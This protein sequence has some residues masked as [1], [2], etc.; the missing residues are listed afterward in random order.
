[1]RSRLRTLAVRLMAGHSRPGQHLSAIGRTPEVASL[2]QRDRAFLLELGYG[3]ERWRGKFDFYIDQLSRHGVSRIDPPV[4][5]TLRGALYE[6]EQMRTPA[7]AAVHE[8]V[9]TCRELGFRSAAGFVNGIL[10][11]F[12]RSPPPLPEDSSSGALAIRTSHPEWL[13]RRYRDR[14]GER[15]AEELL[16]SNNRPSLPH[17]WV[18]PFK[19]STASLS[20]RLEQMSI[21]FRAHPS[22]PD[23]LVLQGRG[24]SQSPDYKAGK[25]LLM[26]PGSQEIAHLP[27]LAGTSLVGDFCAAP[28]GKSFLM[29]ARTAPQS[30]ILCCD[31]SARRLIEM[32]NR[33]RQMAIP[34]LRF[35]I[36]N[37]ATT[38]VC[39]PIFDFVLVD[40][41]CSGL[42]TLRSNP[43]I[44][45]KVNE[46]DLATLQTRQLSILRRA[47][48]VLRRGRELLYSTCSTERDENEEVI[49]L[50]LREVKEAERVGEPHN[51]LSVDRDGDA[52]FAV[53]IKRT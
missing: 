5:W 33:S 4:L 39:R 45:W 27:A 37:W 15:R 2:P 21:P 28:G 41:P 17:L 40:V 35:C 31:R 43:D 34:R 22:L 52:F 38:S 44:R 9:E 49:D 20:R 14:F 10:R 7:R 11:S 16:A 23:C 18:N 36:S 25:A 6:I 50:F 42:G 24:F 12:L 8:A 26:D 32:R 1:M 3:V 47:F 48:S 30:T 29:A 19:S 13:A 46:S 53:S 51:S